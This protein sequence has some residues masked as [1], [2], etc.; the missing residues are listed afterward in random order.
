MTAQ[1]TQV[2]GGIS[3][4]QFLAEYWQKKPLLVRNAMPDVVGQLEPDDILELAKEEGVT[5]RLLTQHGKKNDQWKVKKSP[6]SNKDFKKLPD[7]WTLLVQAVDHFST[8]IA[9]LWQHFDFIPQWRRDD[10]MVS[11]A[12]KGGSVGRHY[13]QYDVFLV[14]GYGQRRWQLGQYCAADCEIMPDQPLRLLPAMDVIFDEVLSPGDL[15]YVPPTLSHYGVAVDDCLTYSFGF[16]M[17]STAQLVDELSHQVAENSTLQTPVLEKQHR[18][19]QP[20]GEVSHADLTFLK[21]QLINLITNTTTFE[22]S[23]LRLLSESKYPDS[24]PD[25]ELLDA[26]TLASLLEQGATIQR[27][28]AIR[29]LYTRVQDQLEFWANGEKLSVPS[30]LETFMQKLADGQVL[31]KHHIDCSTENLEMI[32]EWI[33]ESILLFTE[34]DEE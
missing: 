19:T 5:A 9:E 1:V 33:A 20:V 24:L 14:Q 11:Y 18:S 32:A 2:L 27:E 31:L 10:I 8:D 13:D 16:R 28:P 25:N 3:V 22:Q 7:Y 17:P 30:T 12:P 4:E 26:D 15:L 29:L 6:F 23:V 34:P 21:Q